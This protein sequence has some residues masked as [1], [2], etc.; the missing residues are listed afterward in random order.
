MNRRKTAVTL[1]LA[2]LL[3]LAGTAPA[4]AQF[5]R[6]STN[7]ATI[8]TAQDFSPCGAENIVAPTLNSSSPLS[9]VYTNV[10]TGEPKTGPGPI[11]WE[12]G[13]AW[14]YLEAEGYSSAPERGNQTAAS[15]SGFTLSVPMQSGTAPVLF[16]AATVADGSCAYIMVNGG[17]A[18]TG[19]LSI[20]TTNQN[21][22]VTPAS[23]GNVC[24]IL[25]PENTNIS[26]ITVWFCIE[27]A[28]SSSGPPGILYIQDVWVD[29]VPQT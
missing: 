11:A 24:F 22:Y 6:P 14:G 29:Y 1:S 2:A 23:Y 13:P 7:A 8:Y 27:A 12:S 3:L 16:Y 20:S 18:S 21:C 10:S 19:A 5:A 15:F 26:D 4:K 9:N 28:N 17:G 25:L